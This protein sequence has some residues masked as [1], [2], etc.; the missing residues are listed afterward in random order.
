MLILMS[1]PLVTALPVL[2]NNVGPTL[3][4]VKSQSFEITSQLGGV[5]DNVVKQVQSGDFSGVVGII[6]NGEAA[7]NDML[8]K[9][10][11]ALV[12]ITTALKNAEQQGG[13]ALDQVKATI[14]PAV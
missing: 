11:G 4:G 10:K 5:L 12:N 1:V 6:T 9:T 3:E 2:L 7:I 13:S 8:A 14:T